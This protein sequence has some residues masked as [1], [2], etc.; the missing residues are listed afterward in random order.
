M[1]SVNRDQLLIVAPE[2]IE[3]TTMSELEDSDTTLITIDRPQCFWVPRSG[4]SSYEIF[5]A[6]RTANGGDALQGWGSLIS[7]QAESALPRIEQLLHQAEI[8]FGSGQ[9]GAMTILGKIIIPTSPEYVFQCFGPTHQ[10]IFIGPNSVL[11]AYTP[12]IERRASTSHTGSSVMTI[13]DAAA[14]ATSKAIVKRRRIEDNSED[15]EIIK[16]WRSGKELTRYATKKSISK[17]RILKLKGSEV[18][19]SDAG[20]T[21]DI[22]EGHVSKLLKSNII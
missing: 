16:D 20:V 8:E 10:T 6:Y 13:T 12:V 5:F 14:Q 19:D 7:M 1:P 9:Y 4:P 17:R 2:P 22:D 11:S 21:R 15:D 3:A 18:L